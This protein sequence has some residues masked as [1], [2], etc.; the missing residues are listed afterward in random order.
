MRECRAHNL[1]RIGEI[2]R[3]I[4]HIAGFATVKDQSI[5]TEVPGLSIGGGGSTVALAATF[6]V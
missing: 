2:H 3:T 4:A 6:E 1:H 5:R